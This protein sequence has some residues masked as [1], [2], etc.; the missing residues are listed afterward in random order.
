MS[1]TLRQSL[2]LTGAGMAIIFVFMGALILLVNVFLAIA[3]KAFPDRQD[4]DAASGG[5]VE[6]HAGKPDDGVVAA[7]AGAIKAK[8]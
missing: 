4:D 8:E 2:V 7:I 6:D 1:E 3:R 5:A